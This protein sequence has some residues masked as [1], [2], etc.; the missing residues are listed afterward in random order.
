VKEMIFE[1]IDV[2][3]KPIDMN[4]IIVYLQTRYTPSEI[5]KEN[6]YYYF[7]SVLYDMKMW[8]ENNH[9]FVMTKLDEKT[10]KQIFSSLNLIVVN[11]L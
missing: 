2:N 3:N 8:I 5:S 9:L 1:L 6:E 4:K 10:I 11:K 7:S